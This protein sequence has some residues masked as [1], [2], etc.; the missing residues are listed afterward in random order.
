VITGPLGL[1]STKFHLKSDHPHKHNPK[2]PQL[3]YKKKEEE[4]KIEKERKVE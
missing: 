1:T 3:K 2:Y 4:K